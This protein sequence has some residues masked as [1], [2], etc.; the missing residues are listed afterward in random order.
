MKIKLTD[1][2]N[3]K[4]A[5]IKVIRMITG[6]DLKSA[7]RVVDDI[8]SEI[9]CHSVTTM[10]EGVKELREAGATATHTELDIGA[11]ESLASVALMEEARV[12]LTEGRYIDARR[13]VGQLYSILG[14]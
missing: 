13:I 5:V 10:L 1:A 9:P 14:C 2:G 6:L 7:K 12:A 3:R 11:I 8:P 4:I